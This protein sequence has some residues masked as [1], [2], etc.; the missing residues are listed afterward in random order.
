M[1]Q[2]K[3]LDQELES[4]LIIGKGVD[5]YL[6]IKFLNAYDLQFEG[7]GISIERSDMGESS[8]T[9]SFNIFPQKDSKIIGIYHRSGLPLGQLESADCKGRVN[10][11]FSGLANF[12]IVYE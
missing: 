12:T 9:P 4:S 2:Q 7:K 8:L 6:L 3:S 1:S 5:E 10:I 11:S